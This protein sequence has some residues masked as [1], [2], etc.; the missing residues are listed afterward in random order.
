[1]ALLSA[2]VV[3]ILLGPVPAIALLAVLPT[4]VTML[5]DAINPKRGSAR[6]VPA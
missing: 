4:V 1:M 2:S 6:Q 5:I 3:D